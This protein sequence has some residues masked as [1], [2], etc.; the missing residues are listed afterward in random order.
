M[1]SLPNN[2]YQLLELILLQVSCGQVILFLNIF[3]DALVKGIA[4]TQLFM[5]TT[6]IVQKHFFNYW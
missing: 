1:Y 5:P 2:G 3:E 6:K 4:E